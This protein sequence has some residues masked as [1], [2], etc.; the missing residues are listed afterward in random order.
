MM[1]GAAGVEVRH[2]R[3]DHF[4]FAFTTISGNISNLK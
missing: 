3:G 4:R 2:I 1:G